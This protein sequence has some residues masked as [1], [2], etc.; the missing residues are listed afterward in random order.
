MLKLHRSHVHN[1]P[2]SSAALPDRLRGK[3]R[4]TPRSV[5]LVG[6]ALAAG[7]SLAACNAASASAVPRAA[8]TV[9]H[10]NHKNQVVPLII[11]NG[12]N[13]LPGT[14]EAF[15]KKTGIPTEEVSD[16][17]GV[18]LAKIEAERNNPHWGV[19]WSDG[20]AAYVTLA[21]QG[22]LVR[23]FEPDTGTLTPLGRKLVP[24]DK[25]YIPTAI[26][27]AGA[28]VYNP[29]VTPHPPTNFAQLTETKWRGAVGMNNPA[30]SGPTYTAVAGIMNQM[31][32]VARGEAYFKR[33][34]AN[35]LHVYT[36][37]KV[38]LSALLHGQIKLAIVQNNAGVELAEKYH[39]L[40]VAYPVAATVLP[41]VIGIDAKM[42]K[43][44]IAE[45]KRFAE[46]VYSS[47][48]Q[49]VMQKVNPYG[50]WPIMEGVRKAPL[51]PN[52]STLHLQ[53]LDTPLWGS[54]EATINE[55]FTA[56]IVNG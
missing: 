14:A 40:K 24:A 38:T 12:K 1:E 54:R 15:T 4:S 10:K 55:W 36:T 20:A 11:Y 26:T 2:A 44:E 5:V 25:S 18:L 49:K 39:Q 56:N 9:A 19:F 52:L 35:G 30:I 27:I 34:A 3:V 32:G 22:L 46:F 8:S 29:S 7:V 31:G 16:S 53:F 42:S 23:N 28:I 6:C 47:A 13:Y 21:D 17:T 43:L 33:L 51:L 37:N 41:S 45:A 50:G 48:G